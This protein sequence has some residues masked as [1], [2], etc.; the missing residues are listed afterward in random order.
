MCFLQHREAAGIR[1][2]FERQEKKY[3][4]WYWLQIMMV[5]GLDYYYGLGNCCNQHRLVFLLFFILA[6][7]TKRLKE[8]ELENK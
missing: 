5:Y 2:K 7:L 1:G 6:L 8:F 3:A 4:F